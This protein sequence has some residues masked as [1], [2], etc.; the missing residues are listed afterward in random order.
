M[1]FL[2]TVLENES[3]VLMNVEENYFYGY[4]ML[5]ANVFYTFKRFVII[6]VIFRFNL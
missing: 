5:N 2:T 4:L 6:C 3:D 1:I